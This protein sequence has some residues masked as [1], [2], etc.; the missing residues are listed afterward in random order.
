MFN[1]ELEVALCKASPW[2]EAVERSETDE[3]KCQLLLF[4]FESPS[5]EFYYAKPTFPRGGRQVESLSYYA[6]KQ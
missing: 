1:G 3:G 4:F 5:S 6:A 2:G